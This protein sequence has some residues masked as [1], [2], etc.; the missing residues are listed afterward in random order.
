M[1]VSPRTIRRDVERLRALG[2]PIDS[3]TGPEGGYTLRAGTAMPPLLLDDEEAI[4]VAIALSTAARAA[5][6]GVEEGALRALLKLEQVLPAPLRRRV[7]A[8]GAVSDATP[9]RGGPEVDAETLTMLAGAWRDHEL[10]RFGYTGRD[11]SP[12]RRLVEPHALVVL[13]RR[14]YLLAWD[15]ARAGWRTFRV[16]RIESPS[17]AGTRFS[18]RTVPGGD[19]AG[20]VARSVAGAVYGHRARVHFHASPGELRGG[21]GRGWGELE[22]LPDGTC[23]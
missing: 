7:R 22:E 9:R 3:T 2:Y 14:W 10:V 20:Y 18:E 21:L 16:D 11:G 5:V 1:E 13:G 4:A 12:S 6:S 8:L 23:V 15:P 19:P 17:S